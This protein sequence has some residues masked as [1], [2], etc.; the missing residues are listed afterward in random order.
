M[1]TKKEYSGS[2][3]CVVGCHSTYP[4]DRMTVKFFCFSSKNLEQR[5]KWISAVDRINEDGS[6]WVPKR[7]TRVCSLHFV[8]RQPNPTRT[9]PDYV[10]SLF[11]SN[12]LSEKYSNHSIPWQ[13]LN[14]GVLERCVERGW[15][16]RLWYISGKSK[17]E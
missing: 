16:S 13:A 10:P 17:E 5:E 4:R 12:Q 8:G 3:C 15:T 9:H 14:R 1:T 11:P 7:H 6:P 2:C